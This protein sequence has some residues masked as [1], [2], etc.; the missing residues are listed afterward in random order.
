MLK[1]LVMMMMAAPE[2]WTLREQP[3]KI[4][5]WLLRDTCGAVSGNGHETCT[6][7][8]IFFKRTFQT[9]DRENMICRS[10]NINYNMW[11]TTE[12]P[13]AQRGSPG[14]RRSFCFGF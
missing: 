7:D 11:P 6:R 5:N 12:S 2:G 13:A 3:F 9:L 10:A 4:L 8:V 1:I 14:A